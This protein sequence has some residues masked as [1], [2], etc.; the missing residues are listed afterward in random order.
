MHVRI[1]SKKARPERAVYIEQVFDIVYLTLGLFTQ[2]N[3]A[4][5]A[6]GGIQ[7]HFADKG[8]E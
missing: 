8:A 7:E 6:I 2:V 3:T 1:V 5:N 4:L